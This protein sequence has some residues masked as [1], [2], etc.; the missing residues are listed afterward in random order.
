MSFSN[1]AIIFCFNVFTYPNSNR[2][3]NDASTTNSFLDTN[4]VK[5]I[6]LHSQNLVE[7]EVKPKNEQN[8]T[9]DS[10]VTKPKRKKR[11]AN[12]NR[13]FRR[14]CNMVIQFNMDN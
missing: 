13:C 6:K 12:R 5:N 14:K 9:L 10:P 4:L 2:L 7:L 1:D 8:D 3:E 11:Q